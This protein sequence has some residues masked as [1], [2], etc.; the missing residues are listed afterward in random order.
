M[1]IRCFSSNDAL[2]V[3]AIYNDSK[4]DELRFEE[5]DFTLLPLHLDIKRSEALWESDIYVYD[6]EKVLAYGALYQ[7]EIRALFVSS[8]ARGKGIGKALLVSLLSKASMP[9]TLCVAASNKPAIKLY[10]SFRFKI[11]DTFEADYNGVS[12]LVNRMVREV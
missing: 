12:V 1:T 7:N 3:H 2:A 5:N 8:E 4:L 10:E 9:V 6:D 11:A